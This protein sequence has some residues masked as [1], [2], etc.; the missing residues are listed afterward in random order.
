[1]EGR[2]LSPSTWRTYRKDGTTPR[3]AEWVRR[4]EKGESV[5]QIAREFG[6]AVP[7]MKGMI[8]NYRL[9]SKVCKLNGIVPEGG[10]NV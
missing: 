1:M 2:T 8:S 9:Y 3:V 4:V 5:E 6:Y 10:T 7:T